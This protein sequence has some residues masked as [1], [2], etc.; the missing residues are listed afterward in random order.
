[1]TGNSDLLTD[2]N[3][4]EECVKIQK[5]SKTSNA[6]RLFCEQNFIS[7]T[8]VREVMMLRQDLTSTL[9]EMDLIDGDVKPN[10]PHLNTASDNHNLVKAVML[11]GLWPRV[12]RV[13]LPDSAIKFDKVSAGTV[14]RDNNAKDFKIYDI[15]E[16]RVFLHPGSVLF[17]ASMWRS[18]FLF[19]FNK[20][21]T[22]KLFLRDASEVG[23]RYSSL[24]SLLDGWRIGP[25]VRS[26][27]IRRTGIHQ[28][29]PRRFDCRQQERKH[30]AES[31]T[32]HWDTCQSTEVRSYLSVV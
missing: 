22:S 29:H 10:A 12:A 4:F 26:S 25:T 8:T 11:G 30:K 15:Q 3:A 1:M 32:P 7:M 13:H 5:E 21:M 28:S 20:A 17:G 31:D 6:L 16:G 2:I 14:R 23:P 24:P 9:A 27:F 18:P 19:Y